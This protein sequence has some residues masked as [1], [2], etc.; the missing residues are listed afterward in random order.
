MSQQQ[1]T[2]SKQK[3]VPLTSSQSPTPRVS[4]YAHLPLISPSP[5]L[6]VINSIPHRVHARSI[7]SCMSDPSFNQA[8]PTRRMVV[9][10]MAVGTL[11]RT[12]RA[13]RHDYIYTQEDTLYSIYIL[14]YIFILVYISIPGASCS[15]KQLRCRDSQSLKQDN[16][17][18][19]VSSS[20]RM[21]Q[22][23]VP[24]TTTTVGITRYYIQYIKNA[25]QQTHSSLQPKATKNLHSFFLLFLCASCTQTCVLL[26]LS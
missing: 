6:I 22:K 26:S 17:L 3:K 11:S 5:V 14:Q 24:R 21:N 8:P 16:N 23:N 9:P 4:P 12:G 20:R 25:V 10:T 7:A 19:R 2:T 18:L 15:S 1:N 13:L